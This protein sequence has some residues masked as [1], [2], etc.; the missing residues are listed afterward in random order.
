MDIHW[1]KPQ[2]SETGNCPPLTN[3]L[4]DF[5]QIYG[6]IAQSYPNTI[7]VV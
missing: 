6:K 3:G 7:Y 4:R 2:D 1:V 5:S